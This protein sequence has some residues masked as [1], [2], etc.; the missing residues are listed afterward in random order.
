MTPQSMTCKA[1]IQESPPRKRFPGN[2][3]EGERGGQHA[4]VSEN[5]HHCMP[6]L[7][8]VAAIPSHANRNHVLTRRGI[9][10][11]TE[12][13]FGGRIGVGTTGLYKTAGSWRRDDFFGTLFPFPH[14]TLWEDRFDSRCSG[15]EPMGGEDD[16]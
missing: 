6:H 14:P 13:D 15:L 16:I 9:R 11:N 10:R 5:L 1:P 8:Q 12:P 2:S 3:K 7:A 4:P